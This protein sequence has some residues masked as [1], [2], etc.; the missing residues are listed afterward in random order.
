MRMNVRI[1]DFLKGVYLLFWRYWGGRRKLWLIANCIEVL[2][3]HGA[4]STAHCEAEASD[5]ECCQRCLYLSTYDQCQAISQ[6]SQSAYP[7]RLLPLAP[8]RP[9]SVTTW[10]PSFLP[11]YCPSPSINDRAPTW[12]KTAKTNLQLRSP[13]LLMAV[14]ALV[15]R[16][17]T[18]TSLVCVTRIQQPQP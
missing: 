1:I 2:K 13:W 17:G 10:H 14:S 6:S 11:H 7:A 4:E 16:P 12:P 5:E 9:P 3:M 8:S 15:N 18:N